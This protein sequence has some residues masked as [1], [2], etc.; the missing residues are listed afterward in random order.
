M[1]LYLVLLGTASR[2]AYC[3]PQLVNFLELPFRWLTGDLA[4]VPWAR[5]PWRVL[6]FYWTYQ[7]VAEIRR[8]P[9]AGRRPPHAHHHARVEVTKP[10]LMVADR[11]TL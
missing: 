8:E 2:S 3:C 6:G 7:T 11:G 9:R 5:S 4:P 10:I 1:I